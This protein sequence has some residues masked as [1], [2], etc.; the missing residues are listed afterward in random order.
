MSSRT[1]AISAGI[2]AFVVIFIVFGT[3][4]HNRKYPAPFARAG[5]GPVNPP[6]IGPGG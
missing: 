1:R 5:Q 4:H 6:H 3:W 2:F